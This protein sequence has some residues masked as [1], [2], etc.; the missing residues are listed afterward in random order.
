MKKNL[1]K[2]YINNTFKNLFQT[3]YFKDLKINFYSGKLNIIVEENPI[4]QEIQINGIKNKSILKEL[5]KITRES[6]KYPYIKTNITI[7]KNHQTPFG[8]PVCMV[9]AFYKF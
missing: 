6:E 7:Q 8:A 9:T 4:I 2:Y 5:K 1:P 3:N